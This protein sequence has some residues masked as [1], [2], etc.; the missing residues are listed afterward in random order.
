M[1]QFF[2]AN[3]FIVVAVLLSIFYWL[4][5]AIFVDYLILGQKGIFSVLLIPVRDDELI[6]RFEVVAVIILFSLY[7]QSV[8]NKRH[9]AEEEVK[10]LNDQL[11]VR[12]AE[13]TARLETSLAEHAQVEEE[14][15]ESH[16][17]LR[18]VVEGIAD[19]IFAK[20][21]AGR[22]LLVNSA[23]AEVMD[24]PAKEIIGKDD[25]ELYPPE[26]AQRLVATD[27]RVM[28]GGEPVTLEEELPPVGGVLQTYLSTKAPRR[29]HRGEVAGIIGVAT[30]VTERLR[31]EMQIAFQAQLL[32]QVNAAVIATDMQGNILHWNRHAEVLYGWT[33]HEAL[34]R[35]IA[36]LT[37][38]PIQAEI[39]EEIMEQLRVGNA[40]EGEFVVRRKDGS[41]FPAYVTNSLIYDAQGNAV[42]IVGVS[43]D[44]SDRKQ[45]E[46]VLLEIREA[47]RHRIA[48]DLHDI[49]LQDL[50]S[51]IQTL[52]ARQ[53]E[54]QTA[55]S[56]EEIKVE[57]DTLRRA[58]MGLRDSVHNLRLEGGQPF[59]RTVESLVERNRQLMPDCEVNLFIREGFPAEFPKA[60]GV[61]LLRTV[62]EALANARRHSGAQRVEV[63]LEAD[64][65]EVGVEISDDGEGFDFA[66]PRRGLGIQGM[67]ERAIKFGGSVEITSEA[68]R[69]TVVRIRAPLPSRSPGG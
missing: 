5:E 39:A 69:G 33:R 30:N 43:T 66:V 26:V 12:V 10:R 52:Q 49:V 50:S 54:S 16:A 38:G 2:N 29:D 8:V 57:V 19:P 4:S 55:S 11:E 47:E 18:S 67:Q 61:E 37:V 31:A 3:S 36:E 1:K 40:W 21:A 44:I 17:L 23:C 68:S 41:T 60:V 59:I 25:T 24:R 27:R 13:R 14:L 32:E 65:G 45:L 48:R 62:R 42:G 9:R 64:N 7:A 46:E 53:L 35:D 51:V 20:D 56:G 28:E 15:R 63:R 22:Y 34:D 58:T 6:M